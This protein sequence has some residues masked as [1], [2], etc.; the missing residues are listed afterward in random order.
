MV[1]FSL[2]YIKMQY[3]QVRYAT[4][5]SIK[6]VMV[7]TY[8]VNE[9][10]HD[11]FND[12]SGL[13]QNEYINDVRFITNDGQ[14]FC[15]KLFLMT[16]FPFLAELSCDICISSHEQIVFFLPQCSKLEL[17]IALH[18]M[19]TTSNTD[20]FYKRGHRSSVERLV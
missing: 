11:M 17:G 2:R 10:R 16:A 13:C 20:G 12:L 8:L 6:A 9:L 1:F 19:F 14:L 4:A 18:N 7:L 3:Y 5:D 15:Q